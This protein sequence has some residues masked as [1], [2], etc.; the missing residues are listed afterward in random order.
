MCEF[1]CK[2]YSC[3]KKLCKICNKYKDCVNCL[4]YKNCEN[5]EKV[6]SVWEKDKKVLNIKKVKYNGKKN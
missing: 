2:M 6:F 4:S 5:I 1:N 3:Q